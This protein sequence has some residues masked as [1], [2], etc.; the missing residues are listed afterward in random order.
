MR[1]HGTI[2]SWNDERGFGFIQPDQGGQEIFAHIKA[3][4]DPR[5]RPQPAQPVTFEVEVGP[6]GK[7]RAVNVQWVRSSRKAPPKTQH[8][9]PARWS[10]ASLWA[11]PALLAVLLAGHLFGA[12]PRWT[13]W[14]YPAL[15][16]LTFAVYA[17]DKSAAR[18][19]RWR[20]SEKTLHLLA[21]IGGWPGALLAQQWLRHKSSKTEFRVVFWGTVVLNLVAFGFLASPY[22]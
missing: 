14:A 7:K 1:F 22:G 5:S 6:Q 16:A 18:Q 3:F 12:A 15:S 9:A 10:A 11:L 21:L 19:G 2:K 17:R 20:T 13:L 4:S 8:E